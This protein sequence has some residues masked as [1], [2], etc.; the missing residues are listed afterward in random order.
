MDVTRVTAGLATGA[1]AVALLL[2]SGCAHALSRSS[3]ASAARGPLA[4]AAAADLPADPPDAGSQ[5]D[6]AGASLQQVEGGDLLLQI[7]THTPWTPADLR[8]PDIRSLCAW[9]RN[10]LAQAPGGRLCVV[11][12]AK[13]QSG[14][15]LR[16]TPLDHRGRR[17]GLRDLSGEVLRPSPASLT[18]RVQPGLLRLA[19]GDYRWQLRSRS[20]GIEDRLPDSGELALSIALSTSPAARLRCFGA[21][22]RDPLHACHDPRLRLAVVPTPDVAVISTNAP[23]APLRPSGLLRPCEFGVP[24]ADARAT[25]AV[26]GDSHASH[27]RGALEYVAQHKRWRGVSITRSGC[28]LSR[29]TPTLQP[30]SRRASCRRWN[31]QIPRWLASHPEIHTV[32]VSQHAAADVVAAPGADRLAVRAAGHLAAWKALPSSVRRIVVLRDTPLLGFQN[33]CVRSALAHH[34]DAGRSCALA[35]EQV[36]APDAAVMAAR[37]ARSRRVRV[38]DLTH[39]FCDLRRCMPVVGGALVYMDAEHM[40]NVFSTSL[41]PYVLRAINRDL[42]AP[43][44]T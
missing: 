2:A 1:A 22:S 20:H 37:A 41:G 17:L 40:T 42:T 24:G 15:R 8:P 9:L 6:L 43:G 10:E 38:V 35:R 14:V 25:I 29:A 26:L 28:P 27:W 4:S 5:L 7:T 31:A 39:F 30:S 32:L 3:S 36:L 13:A 33:V 11:P 21:A 34:R 12:A 44:A 18:A 19:P 23:C 16:Y